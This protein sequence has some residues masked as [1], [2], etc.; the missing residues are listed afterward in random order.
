MTQRLYGVL[1]A[2]LLSMLMESTKYREP[3]MREGRNIKPWSTFQCCHQV[4]I[5]VSSSSKRPS[6]QSLTDSVPAVEEMPEGYMC[7][8]ARTHV[9]L[10]SPECVHMGGVLYCFLLY[11]WRQCL[12]VNLELTILDRLPASEPAPG[13]LLLC[14]SSDRVIDIHH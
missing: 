4:Y 5:T 6:G 13:L 1:N 2:A 8:C 12:S 14:P 10:H 11:F 7:V 3:P 9:W